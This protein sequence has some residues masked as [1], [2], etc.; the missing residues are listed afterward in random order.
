MR[1]KKRHDWG[2]KLGHRFWFVPTST[3]ALELG[4]DYLTVFRCEICGKE[5]HGTDWTKDKELRAEVRALG[6]CVPEEVTK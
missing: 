5:I 4:L 6:R 3:I 2:V 1:E